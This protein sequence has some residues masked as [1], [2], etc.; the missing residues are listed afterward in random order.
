MSIKLRVSEEALAALLKEVKLTSF[1]YRGYECEIKKTELGYYCGYVTLTP[2]D[3]HYKA[4]YSN[5]PIYC[6][7]G[8]TYSMMS[9]DGWK[10]GFDC[11]HFG[12]LIPAYSEKGGVFK[13][14]TF[15]IE[16]CKSIVDQLVNLG[17]NENGRK[18]NS[19]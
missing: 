4:P 17:G 11:G 6:H 19:L 10:I 1:L 16:E 3:K 14:A 12:D 13:D 15:C 5:I 7:G 2:E 9:K 18:I 8:I